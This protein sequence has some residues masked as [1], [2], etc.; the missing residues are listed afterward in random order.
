MQAPIEHRS[1][2]PRMAVGVDYLAHFKEMWRRAMAGFKA[3]SGPGDILIFAPELRTSTIYYARV[4]PTPP[5][6][7]SK[8]ATATP[9]P[10]STQRSP[11]KP[12]K[13]AFRRTG[14]GGIESRA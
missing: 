7:S 2:R 13:N 14:D 1:E 8:K 9:N 12:S 3:N 11:T 4:S 10:F 6:D 5:V